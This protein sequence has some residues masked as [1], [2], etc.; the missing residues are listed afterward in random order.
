MFVSTIMEKLCFEKVR[1]YSKNAILGVEYILSL[2]V[3][4]VNPEWDQCEPYVE[5]GLHPA[6]LEYLLVYQI[7]G[8]ILFVTFSVILGVLLTIGRS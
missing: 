5:V 8:V 7:F 6:K 3:K 1:Q 4:S 2:Y